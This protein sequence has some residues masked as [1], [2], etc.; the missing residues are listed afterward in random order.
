MMVFSFQDL[1]SSPARKPTKKPAAGANGLDMWNV[2]VRAIPIAR[3][4]FHL[5]EAGK[6]FA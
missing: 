2:F 1:P 6:A 5:V 3:W 4:T